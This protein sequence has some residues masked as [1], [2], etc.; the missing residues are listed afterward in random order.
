MTTSEPPAAMAQQPDIFPESEVATVFLSFFQHVKYRFVSDPAVYDE[1]LRVL[2]GF[3]T[4]RS[5]DPGKVTADVHAL[6]GGHPDLIHRFE[7]FFLKPAREDPAPTRPQR[8]RHRPTPT[9]SDGHDADTRGALRYLERVRRKRPGLY[10]GLLALLFQLRSEETVDGNEIYERARELFGSPADDGLL[11]GF[12]EYLPVPTGRQRERLLRRRAPEEHHA[13]AQQLEAVAADNPRAAKRPRADDRRR[14]NRRAH[15]PAAESG[16]V[17]AF[18]AELELATTYSKLVDTIRR[19]EELLKEYE[20]N[21]PATPRGRRALFEELFPSREC[22]EVLREMY[23][24]DVFKPIRE[25][26]E[27]GGARTELAL[28]TI[29][30]RLGMLE[31]AAVK[32]FMERRDRARVEG[33]MFKLVFDRVLALRKDHAKQGGAGADRCR[34][35]RGGRNPKWVL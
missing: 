13:P 29:E 14:T 5:P 15:P 21:A 26:L 1:L 19:T 7:A 11:R 31:Q 30:R 9:A 10:D 2:R 24:D 8:E 12:T 27:D 16:A 33:R 17:S 34:R 28:R 32:V 25:A 20:Q 3:G 6:L 35:R 22:Q 4:G 18:R 23:G